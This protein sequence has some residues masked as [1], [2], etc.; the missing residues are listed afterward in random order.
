M[1]LGG[2]ACRERHA[3]IAK[4]F[5]ATIHPAPAL[6]RSFAF[7]RSP[8]TTPPGDDKIMFAGI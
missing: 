2:R 5:V 4:V 3:Q 6:V 1:E 7:P 8:L